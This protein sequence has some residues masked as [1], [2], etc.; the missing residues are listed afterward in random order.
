MQPY[1][2][3][4]ASLTAAN[5]KRTS[6]RPVLGCRARFSQLTAATFSVRALVR[7]CPRILPRFQR[8][9][10]EKG[11]GDEPKVR[12]FRAESALLEREPNQENGGDWP[13]KVQFFSFLY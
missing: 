11:I 4:S 5:S 10:L 13:I 9:I 8:Q 3:P 1:D 6:R 12:V 2:A 7:L